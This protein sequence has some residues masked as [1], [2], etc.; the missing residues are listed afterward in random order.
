M[1]VWFDKYYS[2][3]DEVQRSMWKGLS[4]QQSIEIINEW[5]NSRK[6]ISRK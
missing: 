6:D 3:S 4:R 2:H 5:L 1:Q